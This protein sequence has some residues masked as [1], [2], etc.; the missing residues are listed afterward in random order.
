ME[1]TL[2]TQPAEQAQAPKTARFDIL[3]AIVLGASALATA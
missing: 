2:S 3:S 1:S